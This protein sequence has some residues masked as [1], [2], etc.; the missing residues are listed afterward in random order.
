MHA[1]SRIARTLAA[2]LL[3]LACGDATAPDDEW[4]RARERW[5]RL[6]PR[7][8]AVT[9]TRFCEC[10]PEMSGPVVVTVRDGAVESR[11]Y[12]ATGAPVASPL[13][14][15]FPSVEQLFARI[16]A[17]RRA[18]VDLLR[19]TYDGALGHPVRVEIDPDARVADDEITYHVSEPR[20]LP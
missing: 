4:T 2:A 12:A 19:V 6:G 11:A 20:A 9:V 7:E 5:S 10:L 15:E 1:S 3:A 13:D 17:A 14:A 16:A 18:E 8:Y